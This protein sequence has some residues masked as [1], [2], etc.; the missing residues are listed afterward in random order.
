MP[1]EKQLRSQISNYIIQIQ[2][3]DVVVQSLNHVQLF[4]TPWT[5]VCHASLSFTISLSM[6]RFMSIEL[7]MLSIQL[8]LCYL[9][10]LLPSIFSS[11]RVFFNELALCIRWAKYGSFSFSVSP[12]NEYSGLISFRR[13][14]CS[15]RVSQESIPAPQFE[16]ID[17]S[18]LSLLYC[19]TLIST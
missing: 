8:I 9:L 2:Y 16:G 17:S 6:L 10:L 19:P 13:P 15:P 14:P 7:V 4:V 11:F 3:R 18:A 1:K 12:S 5:T